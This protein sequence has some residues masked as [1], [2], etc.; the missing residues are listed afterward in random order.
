MGTIAKQRPAIIIPPDPSLAAS[1]SRR[2]KKKGP[3]L[4]TVLLATLAF[5]AL[6]H[7]L[8]IT[9]LPLTPANTTTCQDLLHNTDYTKIISLQPKTQEMGA[10]QQTDQL[11]GGQ[12]SVLFPVTD[13]SP[14]HL[15]D[16][17][18]FACTI[19]QQKPTLA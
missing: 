6:L 12:P 7:L 15:L 3:R 4:L 18:I 17:Y 11:T 13:T 10:I 19:Q 2:P 8:A 1:T 14:Q 5:M 9:H 16:V